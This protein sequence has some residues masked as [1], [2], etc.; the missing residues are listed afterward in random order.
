[1]GD[2]GKCITGFLKMLTAQYNTIHF[3]L[4]LSNPVAGI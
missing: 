2:E 4:S 3:A 1:M